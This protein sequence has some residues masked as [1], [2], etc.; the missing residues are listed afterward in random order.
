MK[1][2]IFTCSAVLRTAKFLLAALLALVAL[3]GTTP[4]MAKTWLFTWSTAHWCAPGATT[5]TCTN[6]TT[7]WPNGGVGP[8]C[9]SGLNSGNGNFGSGYDIMA[10][11][12]ITA[13]G[14]WQQSAPTMN[15][16]PVSGQLMF[17]VDYTTRNAATSHSDLVIEFWTQ[18]SNCTGAGNRKV[19]YLEDIAV[20][21]ID[22]VSN[23]WQDVVRALGTT[24]TGATLD[25]ATDGV[26]Q[27]PDAI[28]AISTLQTVSQ[29][30]LSTFGTDTLQTATPHG[31]YVSEVVY[32]RSGTPPLPLV[33]NTPYCVTSVPS[34]TTFSVG[35]VTTLT[36]TYTNGLQTCTGSE[37]A[38]NLTTSTA[39]ATFYA[40][41][42]LPGDS[43]GDCLQTPPA[44]SPSPACAAANTFSVTTGSNS[45][46]GATT[47]SYVTFSFYTK[48]TTAVLISY[49]PGDGGGNTNPVEQKI[50][51]TNFNWS[52][53][54][55]T[56]AVIGDV[57]AYA[58]SGKSWVEWETKSE[59]GT[60]GFYVFR[61]D[62]K[63]DQFVALNEELLPSVPGAR[64]GSVYRYPDSAVV[65]G[66]TYT[67]KLVEIE[68][69]GGKRF[70]GP[71]TVTA[72]SGRPAP[73]SAVAADAPRTAFDKRPDGF[74]RSVH[75][76]N[77]GAGTAP[78]TAQARVAAAAPVTTF[79][80]R[81]RIRVENDGVYVVT[82]AQI[83]A[84]LGKNT[85]DVQ[86]WI[87]AGLVRLQQRGQPVA[88]KADPSGNQLYFYGQA[89]DGIDAVYTRY[90]VYWLDLAPGVTMNAVN[91]STA[92]TMTSLSFPSQVHA[93]PAYN[94]PWPASSPAVAWLS[95][96]DA[97]I[98]Y[99]NY[100]GYDH[101]AAQ[102]TVPVPDV[103]P[104]GTATLTVAL[105]GSTDDT[106]SAHLT[107][108]ACDVGESPSWSGKA[109]LVFTTAPFAASC[110][111]SGDNTVTVAPG[112]ALG[113]D[114]AFWIKSFDVN[115]P[116]A[117][118][119]LGNALKTSG[120]PVVSVDAFN[121]GAIT[122][123]DI[124]NPRL[125][126][127]LSGAS[128][129]GS[130]PYSVKFAAS[131]AAS[132]FAAV[133]KA[134]LAIEGD[135]PSSLKG[136][137]GA[138]YLAIAPSALR[139]GATVL[140][141]Y[142]S[143]MV[144]DLQDVY[145]EFNFGIA[146]PH[147]VQDFLAYAYRNWN[148]RPRYVALVGKGTIDPKGYWGTPNNLFPLLMVSTPNG[149][150][151]SDNRYGDVNGNG[152]SEMAIGRIPARTDSDVTNYVAKLSAYESSRR[153]R[154]NQALLVADALDVLAGDFTADSNRVKQALQTDRFTVTTLYR[155]SLLS[156][157]QVKSGIVAALNSNTGVGLLNYV[158]HGAWNE[159]GIDYGDPL[160]SSADVAS[161][162]NGAHLPIFA[163]F[164]CEVGDGSWPGTTSL[165][166][167][168]LWRVGGGA[169]A[170]FAPTGL[171]DDHQA[172]V[173]NLSFV[174]AIA[175]SRP[176]ATLG[177]A[178][179]AALA[180]FA[181]K[182]AQRYMLDIYQVIGDPA[183]RVQR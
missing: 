57:R 89:I 106:R 181:R 83:A 14:T 172:N 61:E 114:S 74:E 43:S 173:L 178:A 5:A 69:D 87:A 150:F 22:R 60:R 99:W 54:P 88:W 107:V 174:D 142:R 151:N 140:A 171:S 21:D 115:Y 8:Y 119:A 144:A 73:R 131:G 129:T 31:M 72:T 10:T 52:D 93:G 46:R 71:F 32:F 79:N 133:A 118:H 143:G 135:A 113:P 77:L 158:G 110:L 109:P 126:K 101:S 38:L 56:H 145:D 9:F 116:R 112:A 111:S 58:E 1:S 95:D 169:V 163:A 3:V 18:G 29:V 179:N 64:Q 36:G 7:T 132:Y 91:A 160:F 128:V 136:T 154:A 51:F 127:W 130:G 84:Q 20:G 50:F 183:L 33:L 92:G 159:L 105:L 2:R 65:A 137:R 168:L 121:S 123:L 35:N 24:S 45:N 97:E 47:D 120:S 98:W 41:T 103:V 155:D 141:A 86:R 55:R 39:G 4:A 37:G 13:G 67:Y 170:A 19:G 148:P 122:V 104:S 27:N 28:G 30:N 63:T 124:S 177:D 147:A 175:G 102:F 76:L 81:V 75:R 162:N 90:N 134:P 44:A 66:A 49:L 23:S 146:N 85:S 165:S 117:Y 182:G 6:S 78:M 62:P 180:D 82:A 25:F 164:T 176:S 59:I 96:P 68:S 152:L 149:L 125:P 16:T 153:G 11:A 156:P 34:T 166:E 94:A 15:G 138:T 100:V 108:N 12:S 53:A 157:P 167:E 139:T 26:Y 42:W 80:S 17:S 161:L 40:Q 70:Y 48:P